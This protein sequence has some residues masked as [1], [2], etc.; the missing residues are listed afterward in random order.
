MPNLPDPL[1]RVLA[2]MLRHP[3]ALLRGWNWKAASFSAILRSLFFLFANLHGTHHAAAKAMLTEF[4][5]GTFAAGVAGAVIQRLR[6]TEPVRKTALVV[7]LVIPL[8]LLAAQASVHRMM[9]TQ[10]VRTGLIASFIFASFASGFNWFAMRHGAF[11]MGERRSFAHD[12]LLVPGLI[13]Q[14]LFTPLQRE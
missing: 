11:V 6:H 9:G 2:E 14:F 8:V 13:G 10:H 7:W 4:V 1:D 5:Y 12:L 3:L